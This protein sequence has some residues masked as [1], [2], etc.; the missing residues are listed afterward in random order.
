MRSRR[1]LIAFVCLA[2][3]LVGCGDT[4][5]TT[6]R[7]T[8][9]TWNELADFATMIPDDPATAEEAAESIY[10]SKIMP[11]K[12]KWELIKKRTQD[13]TMADKDTKRDIDDAIVALA[14][15]AKLA[16]R[17]V[18][19]QLGGYYAQDNAAK[20]KLIHVKEGRVGRL[21]K[22]QYLDKTI[23]ILNTFTIT[24]PLGRDFKNSRNYWGAWLAP[25]GNQGEP[26]RVPE[27]LEPP[28]GS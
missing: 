24:L 15:E 5:H 27:P 19:A 22:G 1:S 28:P 20:Q 17:R 8:I 26:P 11:L 4:P 10:K 2:P 23:E 14:P 12:K 18:V 25:R 16:L 9:T 6:L 21:P 13:F 3:A 7:D